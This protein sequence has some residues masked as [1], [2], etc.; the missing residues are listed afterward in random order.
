MPQYASSALHTS[1]AQCVNSLFCSDFVV[2]FVY[3]CSK[4]SENLIQPK[5]HF[6]CEPALTCNMCVAAV[7][8]CN[9][10]GAR[11]QHVHLKHTQMYLCIGKRLMQQM[12][13]TLMHTYLQFPVL[14]SDHRPRGYHSVFMASV[15]GF[16]IRHVGQVRVHIL[17]Q[18]WPFKPQVISISNPSQ[19]AMTSCF[20]LNFSTSPMP[21]QNGLI[22]TA[23]CLQGYV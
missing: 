10:S 6:A 15:I 13:N 17:T 22:F 3:S 8:P 5:A 2:P 11:S 7:L 4:R 14:I 19:T 18:A 23:Q 12:S 1:T 9:H 20:P 16:V 21:H